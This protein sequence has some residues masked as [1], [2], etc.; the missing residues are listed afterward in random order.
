M[1]ITIFAKTL[2]P[3]AL[4]A[5]LQDCRRRIKFYLPRNKSPG[6]YFCPVCEGNV[7]RFT[8]LP[9]FYWEELR[10]HN[11]DLRVEDF[12]TINWSAY[13]CPHCGAADRDRLYALYLAETLG[14]EVPQSFRVL[15]IAPAAALSAHIRRKYRISYR[16]ADLYMEG[17][18]DRVDVTNMRCYGDNSFDAFICSHVLEHIPDD[19]KA[20]SELFRIL[21]PGGWGITM[22]PIILIKDEI[23][24]DFTKTKESERW[25]YFGQG[26]HVR[27]YSR[28]GFLGRLGETGFLVRTLNMQHFGLDRLARHG[29][30]TRSA[31]YISKKPL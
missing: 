31:L 11:S 20:M 27:V 19:R 25:K 22:V 9:I 30:S 3:Q 5:T 2:V 15:D 16:T 18:D 26:D 24:E 23:L 12:E 13:S 7:K 6:K 10:K 17:V 29:I 28:L 14:N 8:P 4:R 21:K 1:N